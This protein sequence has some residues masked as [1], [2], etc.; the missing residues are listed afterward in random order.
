[1]RC[2]IGGAALCIA[3]AGL[4]GAAHAGDA[5]ASPCSAAVARSHPLADRAATIASL[6][7]MPESCLKAVLVECDRSANGGLLD[8]DSAALCSMDYE[9][10]LHKAFGGSFREMLAWWQHD[11]DARLVP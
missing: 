5:Q 4:A 3:C 11:R 8:L 2:W 9:A 7:Q 6:E 1:M 10:L